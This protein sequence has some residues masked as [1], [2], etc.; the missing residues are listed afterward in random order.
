MR[1]TSAFQDCINHNDSDNSKCQFYIDVLNDCRHFSSL[2]ILDI[3]IWATAW[4]SWMVL[5]FGA[6][7]I[8]ALLLY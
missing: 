6:T 4:E 7:I 3:C 2:A 5:A 8:H 1:V